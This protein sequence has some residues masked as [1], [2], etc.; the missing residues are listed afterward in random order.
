MIGFYVV[1]AIGIII[2]LISQRRRESPTKRIKNK[3]L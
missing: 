1:L 3:L 2:L